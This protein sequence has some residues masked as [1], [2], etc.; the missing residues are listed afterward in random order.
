MKPNT[1]RP[2]FAIVL[3]M[4]NITGKRVYWKTLKT[5]IIRGR[6]SSI[7][8]IHAEERGINTTNANMIV[9]IKKEVYNIDKI[10]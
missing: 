2:M 7:P 5:I 3:H 10:L 9:N 1:T 8:F 4:Y 6:C